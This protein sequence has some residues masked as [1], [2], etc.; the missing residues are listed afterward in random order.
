MQ[1]P[2]PG[3]R[4]CRCRRLGLRDPEAFWARAAARLPWFRVGPRLRARPIPT[5]R[6][7]VGGETNL[8]YNAVDLHV[9]RRPRR[10]HGAAL[11]E[12]ARRASA[13]SPT[14]SCCDE[15]DARGRRPARAGR[16]PRRPRHPVHADLRRGAR[17]DAGRRPHRRDPLGGVR[18]LRREGAGRSDRRQRIDGGLHRRRDMAQRQGRCRSSPSWTTRCRPT[19]HQVRA[20]RGAAS[21]SRHAAAASA[22]RRDLDLGRVPRG[23]HRPR[24]RPRGDGGERAGVHPGHVGHHGHA[25]AGRAHARRLSGAHRQHG[26]LVLRPEAVRRV[27]GHLRRRLD[28]RPQLHGV[29]A[30]SGRVHDRRLRRRARSPDARSRTGSAWS[31]ATAPRASSPRRPPSACCGATARTRWRRSSTTR[32]SSAWCAPARC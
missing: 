2:A 11:P 4:R 5:F 24:R 6:W 25:E 17:G 13:R 15:V 26:P 9:A 30:A 7:F 18:R 32:R 28:R 31:R 22:E 19:G 3:A 21:A 20:R 12:R 14:G 8:A 29:R 27:V 10:A 1:L 23:R 16:R